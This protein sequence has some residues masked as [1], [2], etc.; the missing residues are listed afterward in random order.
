MKLKSHILPVLPEV[1][2]M[3]T[4]T[5]G[6]I[7]PFF[8]AS[9]TIRNAIRSLILPPAL[10]NS[11]LPSEKFQNIKIEIKNIKTMMNLKR[12]NLNKKN[13]FSSLK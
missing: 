2:S 9:S 6:V 11:H 5:P 8:S 7:S 3:R 1:G 12:T 4:E 13:F 10:K